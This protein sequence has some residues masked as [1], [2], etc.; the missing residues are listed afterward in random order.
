[1]RMSRSAGVQRSN[2]RSVVV[3]P[4]TF[5]KSLS[6]KTATRITPLNTSSGCLLGRQRQTVDGAHRRG[7][8]HARQRDRDTQP[9]RPAVRPHGAER[10]FDAFLDEVDAI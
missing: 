7:P 5:A 2:A 6:V 4:F 1:M 3:T 8:E 9:P 10:P